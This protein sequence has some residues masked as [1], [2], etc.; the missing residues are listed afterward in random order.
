MF[1]LFFLS[2]VINI[3]VHAQLLLYMFWNSFADSENKHLRNK[4]RLDKNDTL[5]I[6]LKRQDLIIWQ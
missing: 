6:R 3:H 1:V 2:A 4:L 5:S